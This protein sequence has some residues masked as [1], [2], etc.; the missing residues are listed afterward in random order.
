MPELN[1]IPGGIKFVN[2]STRSAVRNF[3][4]C[5][6]TP[7]KQN[8]IVTA[9]KEKK[10][11]N[12][13]KILAPFKVPLFVCTRCAERKCHLLCRHIARLLRGAF[14][15]VPLQLGVFLLFIP[16][17]APLRGA[18]PGKL[19]LSGADIPRSRCS[20]K[21]KV[22]T[23]S[24]VSA[25]VFGTRDLAP[26][27]DANLCPSAYHD[28]SQRVLRY[29]SRLLALFRLIDTCGELVIFSL[30][31]TR[32]ILYESS[33]RWRLGNDCI[34]RNNQIE[35]RFFE[36]LNRIG[37]LS[38]WGCTMERFVMIES[39]GWKLKVIESSIA[40]RKTSYVVSL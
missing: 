24:D 31:D 30:V 3:K 10:I 28:C 4:F 16:S 33:F 32:T 15:S 39:F 40:K 6:F 23:V 14:S 13:P 2:S 34:D 8:A 26:C 18:A 1:P 38:F 11:G 27:V 17:F 7:N 21:V 25:R 29:A 5:K 20:A 19:V 35:D 22:Y 9:E 37:L 12:N 36:V